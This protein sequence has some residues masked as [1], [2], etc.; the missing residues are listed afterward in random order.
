M[1][2]ISTPFLH[3]PFNKCNYPSFVTRVRSISFLWHNKSEYN[4]SM[5]DIHL[6]IMG[7]LL[8]ILI[9][10]QLLLFSRLHFLESPQ[11]NPDQIQPS[12]SLFN[13]YIGE[14]HD[15]NQRNKQSPM[16]LDTSYIESSFCLIKNRYNANKIGFYIFLFRSI[17]FLKNLIM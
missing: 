5:S 6:I 12:L 16:Q 14:L 9:R 11:I 7:V 3:S 13:T 15:Y 10:A 8:I 2:D 4:K 17:F 1:Q